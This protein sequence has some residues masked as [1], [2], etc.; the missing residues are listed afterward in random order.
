MMLQLQNYNLTVVYKSGPGMYI[1]D[2][3]SR[4][5]FNKQVSDEP[6]LLQHTESTMDSSPEE[7]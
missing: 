2:V 3:L 6:G 7:E 4:A 1:S 5:V